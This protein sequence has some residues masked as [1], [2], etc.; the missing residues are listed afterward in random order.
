M[1]RAE[2]KR[3]RVREAQDAQA[4]AHQPAAGREPARGRA[5]HVEAGGPL[6]TLSAVASRKEL[7]VVAMLSLPAAREHFAEGTSGTPGIVLFV[8][9]HAGF[10]GAV[11]LPRAEGEEEEDDEDDDDDDHASVDGK[12][13]NPITRVAQSDSERSKSQNF[14]EGKIVIRVHLPSSS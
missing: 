13:P 8:R 7:P 9:D 3:D 12:P 4:D 10:G 6:P 2:R 5:V 14:P 11:L 1:A